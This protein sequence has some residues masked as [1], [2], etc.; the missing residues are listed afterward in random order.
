MKE[1]EL[2]A[3][4]T[5]GLCGKP[6]GHCGVP[7]FYRV[8]VERHGVKADAIRRQTGLAM[9]IGS[10]ALAQ[11]MGPDEEMTQPLLEPVTITVCEACST[12]PNCVAAIA[13]A[14]ARHEE[15]AA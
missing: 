6:F 8:T 2:R 7:F 5:C 14:A 11:V 3:A 10:A 13:E 12:Q 9:Q 4:A 15:R 1:R